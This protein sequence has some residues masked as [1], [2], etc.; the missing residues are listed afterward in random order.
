ME[1]T[2]NQDRSIAA[3]AYVPTGDAGNIGGGSYTRVG[4]EP[5]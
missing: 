3:P 2:R 5:R 1:G 4:Q